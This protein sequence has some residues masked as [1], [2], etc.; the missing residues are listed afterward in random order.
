MDEMRDLGGAKRIGF[1]ANKIRS[2][3]SNI[4]DSGASRRIHRELHQL[5]VF[6]ANKEASKRYHRKPLSEGLQALESF[7]TSSDTTG[8]S[9]DW[10][11]LWRGHPVGHQVPGK[12]SGDMLRGENAR[13]LAGLL[14]KRLRAAFTEEGWRDAAVRGR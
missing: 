7:A 10:K 8:W 3:A 11:Y 12:D 4:A 6:L 13:I 1:L 14:A 2:L 9:F 5:E